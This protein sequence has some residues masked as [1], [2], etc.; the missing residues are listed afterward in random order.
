M[1]RVGYLMRV[2]LELELFFNVSGAITGRYTSKG[3]DR[4][5]Y[6]NIQ[7]IGRHFKNIFGYE[8]TVDRRIISADYST[9]ELIAGCEIMAIGSMRDLIMDGIDLHKA[10][11]SNITGKSVSEIT[12]DER[13]GAKAVN[14][15]Y[16]F[17]LGTEKF[18][19]YAYDTYGV[20]LTEDECKEYKAIYYEAHPEIKAYHKQMGSKVKKSGFLVKTAMGRVVHP[21]RYADA[22]NIPVQGTIGECTKMAQNFLFEDYGSLMKEGMMI[23]YGT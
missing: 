1:R 3:G 7:N 8:D 11:A 20:K 16:L 21:D 23:K 15:G 5:G 13:Q 2:P 18:Q 6:T 19:A 12:K 14:F 4:V 22:L 10:M 17:G 9:A